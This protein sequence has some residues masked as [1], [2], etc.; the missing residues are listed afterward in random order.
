MLVNSFRDDAKMVSLFTYYLY[1]SLSLDCPLSSQSSNSANLQLSNR[2]YCQKYG[3][4]DEAGVAHWIYLS[5][6]RLDHGRFD[7]FVSQQ[8]LY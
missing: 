7:I 5:H 4:L 6:R 8:F 1:T 2:L 3:I